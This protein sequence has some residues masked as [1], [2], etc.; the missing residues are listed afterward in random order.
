[1]GVWVHIIVI[2]LYFPFSLILHVLTLTASNSSKV[3]VISFVII[4]PVPNC[5]V[6]FADP[7]YITVYA[8]L[9]ILP[10]LCQS[11][12]WSASI[13]ILF[14]F[15][16]FAIYCILPGCIIILTFHVAIII[17]FIIVIF[18]LPVHI[19]SILPVRD[20]SLGFLTVIVLLEEVV[21]L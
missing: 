10:C 21:S 20:W 7:L 11:I 14:F 17:S 13:S 2:F 19:P 12:S 9:S 5:P 6:L 8:C 4:K 1:M 18:A 16:S 15:F 3:A